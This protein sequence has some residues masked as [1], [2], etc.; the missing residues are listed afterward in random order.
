[1]TANVGPLDRGIRIFVGITLLVLG[2]L[3]VLTGTLAIIAYV[4]AAI[5]LLTGL[6]RFCPAWSVCD[7]NTNSMARK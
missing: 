2:L 5:A 1:M 3:H 7:I 4:V 6:I